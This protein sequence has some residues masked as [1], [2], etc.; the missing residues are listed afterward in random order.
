MSEALTQLFDVMTNRSPKPRLELRRDTGI[1]G[2]DR[3][4]SNRTIDVLDLVTGA[5]WEYTRD[6]GKTWVQGSG[7]SFRLPDGLYG[8]GQVA[9]RQKAPNQEWSDR[10][11]GSTRVTDRFNLGAFGASSIG[12]RDQLI[13]FESRDRIRIDGVS[14]NQTLTSRV[15]TLGSLTDLN[16]EILLR[17]LSPGATA[18]FQVRGFEGTFIAFNDS[19]RGFQ[20]L[21]DGMAFLPGYN[22][23]A[24]NPIVVL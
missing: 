11:I 2:D 23:S 9:A 10:L 16:V 8:A 19:Q 18:A 5:R 3:I 13:N 12:S 15:G 21:Q 24:T 14:F 4:T 20:S 7:R 17:N 22:V 6:Y 1:S